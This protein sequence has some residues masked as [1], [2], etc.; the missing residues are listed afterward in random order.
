[1]WHKVRRLRNGS[2]KWACNVSLFQ[3]N[4]YSTTT[5]RIL[6]TPTLSTIWIKWIEDLEA[7]LRMRRRVWKIPMP[8]GHRGSNPQPFVREWDTAATRRNSP[9]TAP[10]TL[11][12]SAVLNSLRSHSRQR[13]PRLRTRSPPTWQLAQLM[14]AP[15]SSRWCRKPGSFLETDATVTT[16]VTPPVMSAMASCGRPISRAW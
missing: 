15:F 10:T 1:M 4:Y 3:S 16:S 6:A 2:L 8:V 5:T 9:E 13:C 7:G 14:R 12:C 11:V